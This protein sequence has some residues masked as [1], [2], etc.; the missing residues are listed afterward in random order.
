MGRHPAAKAVKVTWT[1]PKQAFP[2]QTD[3]YKHMRTVAPKASKETHKQGDAEAAIASA[4]KRMEASYEFPFQSH[5]TMGPG[6]AV[7]DVHVDGI[8]TVWSGGQKPHDLQKGFAELLHV[9]IDKVRVIWVEDAGSYGR[10]G[11]EDA[12]ADAVVLSQA[13]GKP[14]RVQWMRD[15]MHCLGRERPR[16][17]LRHVRGAYRHGRSQSGEFHFASRFPAARQCFAPDAAGNYLV[18]QLTGIPQYN[19]RR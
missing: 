2:E 12:A 17:A 13:V 9:D 10:P 6:C 3:L 8:T 14:V 15:D 5:A 19:R 4:A 1:P 18:G 16:R 7:A 11:F